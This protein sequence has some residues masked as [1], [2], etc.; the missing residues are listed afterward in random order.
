[1][2]GEPLNYS[3]ISRDCRVSVKTIQEYVSILIDTLIV[4]R[5]DAWSRSIRKQIIKSPK[6]Y[7]FDCGV[8]NAIRGELAVEIKPHS[9]RYGKLF[10]TFIIQEIIRLNDY[11]ESG[12]R[13][14]YWRT[15]SGLE[16][17][18]ILSRGVSKSIIAIEIKSKSAPGSED[19]RSLESF[20]TENPDS[21]LLCLCTSIN[22]YL[23]GSVTVLPWKEGLRELFQ[24]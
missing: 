4:I 2:N 23:L 12:F 9:Y 10:E 22:R 11:L 13:F 24:D 15:N 5:I 17:D 8:L 19:I 1:M 20:K 7:F 14:F 6:I 18:I 3:S 16:V 21:R